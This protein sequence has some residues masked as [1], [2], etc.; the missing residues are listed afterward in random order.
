MFRPPK[1]PFGVAF[2]QGPCGIPPQRKH[3]CCGAQVW[4]SG[5]L[6]T[7]RFFFHS[8]FD[9]QRGGRLG[10]ARRSVALTP[11]PPSLSRPGL[12]HARAA[13]GSSPVWPLRVLAAAH[14][15]IGILRRRSRW[16]QPWGKILPCGVQ[17]SLYCFRLKARRDTRPSRG[18]HDL[19]H[20]LGKN[21]FDLDRPGVWSSPGACAFSQFGRGRSEVS[22]PMYGGSV[23]KGGFGPLRGCGG[24]EVRP[25]AHGQ[26]VGCSS[27]ATPKGMVHQLLEVKWLDR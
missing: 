16:S 26:E 24:S 8:R 21:P 15:A 3:P 11:H 17:G 7:P 12:R 14:R 5:W 23:R 6:T 4:R 13:A 2:C 9:E 20:P 19:A 22:N 1:C 10:R 27:Q 25:T 18:S